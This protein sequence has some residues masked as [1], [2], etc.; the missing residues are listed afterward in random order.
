MSK[1]QCSFCSA[2]ATGTMDKL[3]DL[4]WVWCAISAPVRLTVTA[5]P[6]HHKEL[7]AKI[8][9]AA[10]LKRKRVVTE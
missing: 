1:K 9:E 7:N 6:L 8:V 5:C 10:G 3:I 4:G 2:T